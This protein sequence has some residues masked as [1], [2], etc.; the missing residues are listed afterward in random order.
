MS[1]EEKRRKAAEAAENRLKAQQR[2]GVTSDSGT[3][4]VRKAY[5]ELPGNVDSN[6]KWQVR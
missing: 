1:E 4:P 2:R 3:E 5:A 6:L